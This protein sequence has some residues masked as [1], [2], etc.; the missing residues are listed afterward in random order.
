MKF[1]SYHPMIN[2]IYFAA[3]IA[4]TI[5]FKQPV[6]LGISFICAFAYS[7][8]L[9]GVK[10]ILLNLLFILLGFGYALRYTSYE[11]FGVTVLSF[12]FIGNQITL[13]SFVYGLTNGLIF[14][15]VCMWFCCIFHLSI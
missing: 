10:I 8:K 7:T 15:T 11:H 5:C 4:C 9:C 1:D 13:E 3:A 6:F 2:F 14:A 12:N